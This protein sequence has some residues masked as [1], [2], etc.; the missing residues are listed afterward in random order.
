MGYQPISFLSISF[1]PSPGRDVVLIGLGLKVSFFSHCSGDYLSKNGQRKG[2]LWL[3]VHGS[4]PSRA[5]V[6]LHLQLGVS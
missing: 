2:L 1:L 4:S 6:T 3:T 5:V